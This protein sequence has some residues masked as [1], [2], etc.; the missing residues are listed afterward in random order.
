MTT[1]K[2][3]ISGKTVN[4][5]DSKADA[6]KAAPEAVAVAT[7]EAD[8]TA[9][10]KAELAEVKKELANAN[11]KKNR[12]EGALTLKV[13]QKGCVSVYGMGRFP[14]SLYK[15]QWKR[16]AKEMDNIMEFIKVNEDILPEKKGAPTKK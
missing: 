4:K 16:L 12:A 2:N 9:Q 5:A 11:A 1:S 6:P 3:L 15:S 8:E 10:L 7:P 14:Q 13:S